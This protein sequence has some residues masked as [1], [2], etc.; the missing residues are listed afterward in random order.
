MNDD[1][2]RAH[3]H[4]VGPEKSVISCML[5]DPQQFVPLAIENGVTSDHFYDPGRRIVF[6][7][8]LE[9]FNDNK[10]IDLVSFVQHLINFGRIDHVGG[11]SSVYDLYG[12]AFN[13][14]VFIPHLNEVKN[15]FLL[16]EM[17]NM[18]NKM[19]QMV[20]DAPGEP[21][22]TLAEADRLLTAIAAGA[23]GSTPSRTIKQLA[24]EVITDLEDRA[25]GKTDSMGIEMIS[26]IDRHLKGAHPGRMMVIGGYPEA[27]KSLLAMQMILGPATSGIP[28][29]YLSLELSEKDAATRAMIQHSRVPA[30]ALSDPRANHG[31]DALDKG[32]LMRI[33]AA[34]TAM[35]E[36][37]LRIKRCNNRK[38][39]TVVTEIR[40]AHREMG[41]KIAVV[42]YAQK[43]VGPQTGSKVEEYEEISHTLFELASELAITIILPS[44]LNAEGDTKGG[45]V[46]EEDADD[47]L[48]IVQDRNKE[49]PTYKAHKHILIVKNRHN[50]QGGKI[51]PMILNHE[52]LR[53]VHGMDETAGSQKPKFQR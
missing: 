5:S 43:I 24:L 7:T 23:T 38:L 52:S 45:R 36:S 37:S 27:G 31:G 15:Q 19:T 47:V 40:K 17:L 25:N 10:E 41:I 51:I 8:I 14:A 32:G 6:E 30:S 20:Y 12:Y 1:V 39:Q 33:R 4:A 16:R 22:E 42:D 11:S 49:S 26:E 34:A 9:L 44:Q 48:N 53:F 35:G 50:S 13:T 3:P 29:L 21:L 2:T 18:A 46:F 28:C